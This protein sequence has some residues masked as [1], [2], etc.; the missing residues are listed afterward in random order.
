MTAST[1]LAVLF[2]PSIFVVVQRFEEWR[3]ARK[4]P[5]IQPAEYVRVKEPELTYGA[6]GGPHAP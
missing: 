5:R 6:A 3:S 2:A 1:C 4:H